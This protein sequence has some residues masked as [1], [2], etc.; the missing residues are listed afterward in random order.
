MDLRQTKPILITA[1]SIAVLPLFLGS[2]MHWE[3]PQGILLYTP[4]VN[5]PHPQGSPAFPIGVLV[6]FVVS[7][8]LSLVLVAL[9]GAA[10]YITRSSSGSSKAKAKLF[11][12]VAVTILATSTIGAIG[13]LIYAV[14]R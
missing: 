5:N 11:C 6:G 2:Y 9:G 12:K 7:F 13:A 3:S 10:A 4:T 1:L 8:L 14:L